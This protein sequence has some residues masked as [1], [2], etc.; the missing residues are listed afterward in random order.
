MNPSFSNDANL[1]FLGR[2]FEKMV[3]ILARN[4]LVVDAD[5]KTSSL[6]P[7]GAVLRLE[8]R[9]QFL[10]I[11]WKALGFDFSL[12]A[13]SFE[14]QF[15]FPGEVHSFNIWQESASICLSSLEMEKTNFD[16]RQDLDQILAMTSR[17]RLLV[18]SNADGLTTKTVFYPASEKTETCIV[19]LHGGP[20]QRFTSEYNGL[21]GRLNALGLDIFVPQYRGD[22][23]V[24]ND[25][26]SSRPDDE[27]Q[28]A[29]LSSFVRSLQL[30]YS[31]VIC[32]THSY[33]CYLGKQLLDAGN[34]QALISI[35]GVFDM[36]TLKEL[37]PQTFAE[38]KAFEAASKGTGTPWIHF[39]SKN[40]PVVPLQNLDASLHHCGSKPTK[41]EILQSEEHEIL[42]SSLQ[43][44][45]VGYI[46]TSLL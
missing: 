9:A 42:D 30:N 36:E 39:H 25:F 7:I 27:A 32:L 2:F 12:K 26:A 11:S 6:T 31:K 43:D 14:I 40:D 35:N 21:L 20:F 3:F 1:V 18:H 46:K 4:W 16:L 17:A 45:M 5:A 22:P 33:G 24:D 15:S 23:T 37:A 8:S 34:I 44:L 28:L 29:Q 10:Q 38:S 13:K 41:V 19:Y